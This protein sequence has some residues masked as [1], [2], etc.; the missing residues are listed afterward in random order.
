MARRVV[1]GELDRLSRQGLLLSVHPFITIRE[2]SRTALQCD[3]KSSLVLEGLNVTSQYQ[4][5]DQLPSSGYSF[6]YF[7]VSYYMFFI[8]K[9][10]QV[11]NL[12]VIA[13]KNPQ[14]KKVEIDSYDEIEE[15]AP[16]I[17]LSS[18]NLHT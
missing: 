18:A 9:E 15:E 1:R 5:R 17:P 2:N 3:E 8:T 4:K 6:I 10:A 7:L 16:Q 12:E 14:Q 13:I 11:I